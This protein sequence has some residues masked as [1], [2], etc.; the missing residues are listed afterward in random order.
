MTANDLPLPTTPVK[1]GALLSAVDPSI[2]ASSRRIEE[3][4]WDF[5][6]T[7]E[8]VSFNIPIANAFMSLSAAA[9]ATTTIELMSSVT[10]LPLYP[11]VLA[12]KLGAALDNISGGR[13]VMGV[14]VGGENPAEFEACGVPLSQRGSRTDEA[15]EIIRR[16][17]TE[18]R[19]T[20]AGRYATLQDVSIRPRPVRRPNPPIW[21][22][23]RKDVAI[24]R[25][26]VHGDGWMPYMYSP[27]MLADSL[28]KIAAQRAERPPIEA[29]VY[30]W[31]CVHEDRE[32]AFEYAMKTMAKTYKQD[33]TTMADKY[34]LVGDVDYCVQRVLEY[35]AA[36]ATRVI[37][38]NACPSQYVD[39]NIETLSTQV[40]AAVRA[41]LGEQARANV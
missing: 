16:L 32:V 35:I 28:E 11:A 26:A 6:T 41:Q 12:A 7:G 5:L 15:L 18:E 39:Q 4:G 19:V 1:F 24:R 17:W 34:L 22:A 3:Q 38:A 29:G 14:G 40:V 20:Y 30:L 21:I 13:F 27:P 23:G 33:F 36:G 10:L 2:V 8:H 31:S 9:A 37:F 25:A